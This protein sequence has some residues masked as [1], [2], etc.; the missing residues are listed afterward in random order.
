MHSILAMSCDEPFENGDEPKAA[1]ANLSAE[2]ADMALFA[3][4]N[5]ANHAIGRGR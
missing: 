2:P 4:N 1:G 5:R 3:V